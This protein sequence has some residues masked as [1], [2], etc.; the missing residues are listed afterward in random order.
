MASGW[1]HPHPLVSTAAKH[2]ARL[3]QVAPCVCSSALFELNQGDGSFPLS[4]DAYACVDKGVCFLAGPAPPCPNEPDVD[5]QY[6]LGWACTGT[7]QGDT[8][9]KGCEEEEGIAHTAVCA[10][11]EWNVTTIFE[12]K[13]IVRNSQA[14][15]D[16][17]ASCRM[18][19]LVS[20]VLMTP[21]VMRGGWELP[22]KYLFNPHAFAHAEKSV[23]QLAGPFFGCF[24]SKTRVVIQES[25]VPVAIRDVEV[26]QHLLCFDGGD[27]MLAPGAARWCELNSFVSLTHA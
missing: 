15:G 13:T 27:D 17:C 21:R 6:D 18:R 22:N 25:P 19:V 8:C 23:W 3:V 2:V 7:K 11:G 20:S 10:D 4:A 12:C 14:C 16:D 1:S 26:G 5:F 24:S 9:A